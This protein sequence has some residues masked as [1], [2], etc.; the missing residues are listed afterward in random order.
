MQQQKYIVIW[1]IQ[2]WNSKTVCKIVH[3]CSINMTT[4][5]CLSLTLLTSKINHYFNIHFFN[6]WIPINKSLSIQNEG[7][8]CIFQGSYYHFHLWIKQSFSSYCD[9]QL[10]LL[11]KR[12]SNQVIIFYPCRRLRTRKKIK[13]LLWV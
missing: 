9:S 6:R 3:G 10:S 11:N 4:L 7:I 12:S 13:N 8:Q 5:Q 2:I 1:K